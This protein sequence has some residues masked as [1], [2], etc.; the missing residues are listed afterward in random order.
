MMMLVLNFDYEF[1][2][3]YLIEDCGTVKGDARILLRGETKGVDC[4][5]RR[6]LHANNI[7]HNIK[8]QNK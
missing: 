3:T 1:W 6:L 8:T 4:L 2:K 7:Y 5:C